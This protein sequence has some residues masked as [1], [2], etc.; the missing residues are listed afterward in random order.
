MAQKTIPTSSS[1]KSTTKFEVRQAEAT[2]IRN[3]YPHS[4]PIIVEKAKSSSIVDIDKK[5]FL[6]AHDL[7]LGDFQFVIRRRINLDPTSN[8]FVYCKDTL[9]QASTPLSSL[10]EDH[11]DPDG[12]LYL[13]YSGEHVFGCSDASHWEEEPLKR[14]PEMPK[15]PLKTQHFFN[16][17]CARKDSSLPYHLLWK[18][19]W[20]HERCN[21]TGALTPMKN[22]T[23]KVLNLESI[24]ISVFWCFFC[25]NEPHH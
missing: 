14:D 24:V 25:L 6:A 1:Y 20:G 13:T 22:A 3:K 4:I 19:S 5:K 15:T 23:P 21:E 17:S 11:R 16:E 18:M 2:R 8:I 9:P 12:F 10:Y 7:T